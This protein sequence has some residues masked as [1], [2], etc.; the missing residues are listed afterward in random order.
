MLSTRHG[1][2]LTACALMLGAQLTSAPAR[3]DQ[4]VSIGNA[5]AYQRANLSQAGPGSV[6][7]EFDPVREEPGR[8]KLQWLFPFVC[9]SNKAVP[10]VNNQ[11][12][13]LGGNVFF[14]ASDTTIDQGDSIAP[15]YQ[16]PDGTPA[17]G[18]ASYWSWLWPALPQLAFGS[19]TGL[20]EAQ[21][22]VVNTSI[23][24]GTL[25]RNF[26]NSPNSSFRRAGAYLELRTPG[27]EAEHLVGDLL[28]PV[29]MMAGRIELRPL[30]LLYTS[31]VRQQPVEFDY[32]AIAAPYSRW[33]TGVTFVTDLIAPFEQTPADFNPGIGP[34]DPLAS[35]PSQI[36]S[37]V[38][39]GWENQFVLID[40]GTTE[41]RA[42]VDLNALTTIGD[43]ANPLGNGARLGLGG[44]VGL[45]L[46]AQAGKFRGRFT[47]EANAGGPGYV[48]GYFDQLYMIERQRVIGANFSKLWADAPA[49]GGYLVRASVSYLPYVNVYVEGSDQLPLQPTMCQG[50]DAS[51]DC[52]NSARITGGL[53]GQWLMFGGTMALSQSGVQNY[54][55]DLLGP[56]LSF[57]AEGRMS[58]FFSYLQLLTRFYAVGDPSGG[59]PNIGGYVGL[60]VNL[61]L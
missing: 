58:L 22:G 41:A 17:M 40:R 13:P 42:Y 60:E 10:V 47:A 12:S 49:S 54:V 55:A 46:N 23:G 39:L 48:P 25:V 27:V 29:T 16:T 31:Q 7:P 51:T 4:P 9:A 53:T 19:T 30:T 32:A 43:L 57:L 2:A 15:V 50:A 14:C 45:L 28:A 35:G 6:N 52:G 33:L 36:R 1:L 8:F 61:S 37:L 5:G 56:G 20:Y 38:A 3:A 59:A 26:T 44:H 11:P 24:N 21:L 18:Q 34:Y